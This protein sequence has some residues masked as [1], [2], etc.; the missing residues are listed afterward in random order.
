MRPRHCIIDKG[1]ST[2]LK[3][4]SALPVPHPVFAFLQ[5]LASLRMQMCIYICEPIFSEEEPLKKKKKS[6]GESL[7]TIQ[8]KLVPLAFMD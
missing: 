8:A 4:T 3:K 6:E 7:G 5:L 2:S 1:I